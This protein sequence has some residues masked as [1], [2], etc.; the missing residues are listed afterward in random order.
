MGGYAP[1]DTLYAGTEALPRASSEHLRSSVL[2]ASLLASVDLPSGLGAAV[3]VPYGRLQTKSDITQ[4]SDSGLGDVELRLRQDLARWLA[5]DATAWPRLQVS[6][7]VVAP[8]GPYVAKADLLQGNV[9]DRY[10]SLGRG[11]W[12]WLGELD[13]GGAITERFGWYGSAAVR[14]ALGT[15]DDQFAWGPELR[16]G[17]GLSANLWQD[18]VSGGLGVD[19][20][21]RGGNTEVDYKGDRVDAQNGGGRW[22]ELVPTLRSRLG[23]TLAATVSGR[24][25]LWQDVNGVQSV[26]QF[27]AFVALHGTFDFGGAPVQQVRTAAAGDPAKRARTAAAG[28]PPPPEVAAQVVA[29]R[30]TLV[31]YWATWCTPCTKLAKEL[32]AL[33]EARP[34][35]VVVKVD[36]TEWDAAELQ[37]RLPG[38]AG[39]PLLDVYGPDGRLVQRL[40]GPDAFRFAAFLPAAA[41]AP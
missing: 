7:G 20:L 41:T 19:H 15:T 26:Q 10:L 28:D 36:A 40:E 17:A 35:F 37:R 31:D 6:L 25:P 30:W 22:L 14:G 27:A 4:T 32:Q 39:L 3:A 11:A 16:T 21:W 34:E 24:L 12:W 18:I 33:V 9:P 2:L 13:A 8:T 38:V 23:D 1:G 29:G 5:P